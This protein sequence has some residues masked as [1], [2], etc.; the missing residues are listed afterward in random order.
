MKKHSRVRNS[1]SEIFCDI[2]TKEAAEYNCHRRDSLSPPRGEPRML[3][4]PEIGRISL[5]SFRFYL[6]AYCATLLKHSFQFG[7]HKAVME[8]LLPFC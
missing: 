4:T 8:L 3:S 6:E 7:S 2:K 1:T 5:Y